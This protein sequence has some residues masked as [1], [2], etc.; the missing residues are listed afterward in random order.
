MSRTHLCSSLSKC[1][2]EPPKKSLQATSKRSRLIILA[3]NE[4]NQRN[5]FICSETNTRD[6]WLIKSSNARKTKN[7]HLCHSPLMTS[8]MLRAE[9]RNTLLWPNLRATVSVTHK[10]AFPG[11]FSWSCFSRSAPVTQSASAG[12]ELHDLEMCWSTLHKSD[13]KS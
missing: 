1:W 10:A 3:A 5:D 4:A 9:L 13:V 6:L 7:P 12:S 2:E 11:R 8:N